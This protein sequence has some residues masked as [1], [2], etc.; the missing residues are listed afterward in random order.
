MAVSR[1][2]NEY[3]LFIRNFHPKQI[4]ANEKYID[5]IEKLRTKKAYQFVNTYLHDQIF[6]N[7]STE[8]KLGYLN[9]NSILNKVEDIDEDKNL[10]ELDILVLS[11]EPSK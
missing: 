11:G 7:G 1:V 2:R 6:E 10:S 5:E 9:I 3:S 4:F 8:I